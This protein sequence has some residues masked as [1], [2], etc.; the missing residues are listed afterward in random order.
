MVDALS[1]VLRVTRLTGGVFLHADFFAP[2][3]IEARMGPEHCEPVLGPASHLIPY[4]YLVEGELK[5]R[6]SGD[7]GEPLG[8]RAGEV[9]MLPRNDLHVMGSDIN[10]TPVN[11]ADLIQPR[12]EGGLFSIRHGGDGA[13]TRMICGFLGCNN[14]ETNPV[15]SALPPVLKLDLSADAAAEWIHPP[16][17]SPRTKWRRDDRGPRPCSR[18]YRS[19]CSWK[20]CGATRRLCR[21]DKR[22]GWQGCAMSMSRA[23]ALVHRDITRQWTVDELGRQVGLSRSALADRFTRLLGAPPMQYLANWRMHVAM[24]SLRDSRTSLAEVADMVGYDSESAFSRALKKA[25]G[26]APDTWRRSQQMA[27]SKNPD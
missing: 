19:F 25:I 21:R 18:S 12:N 5:L 20:R 2:W 17:D 26:T 9:V 14:A 4:H 3:C 7:Y 1:D 22:G 6:I 16:F 23:L 10:L 8:L 13:R 15:I 27:A 11:N 24:Q